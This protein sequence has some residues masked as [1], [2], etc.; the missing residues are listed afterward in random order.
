MASGVATKLI[1][2]NANIVCRRT[3][4]I[5]QRISAPVKTTIRHVTRETIIF[6][7]SS[8]LYRREAKKSVSTNIRGDTFQESRILQ[9]L[10]LPQHL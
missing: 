8:Q 10:H 3:R 2:Q 5:L 4:L 9:G 7:V 1:G 6:E